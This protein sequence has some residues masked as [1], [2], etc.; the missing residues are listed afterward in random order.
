GGPR[1]CA[2]AVQADHADRCG[3]AGARGQGPS[4]QDGDHHRHPGHGGPA[5]G[6]RVLHGDGG[7]GGRRARPRG[8]GGRAR[9]R[10]RR[11]ALAG[12]R[13]DRDPAHPVAHLRPRPG[14]GGGP[15]HGGAARPDPRVRRRGRPAGGDRPPR[16]RPEPVPGAAGA[17][18]GRG[19][20]SRA[21]TVDQAV[22][23]AAEVLA[24]AGTVTLLAHLDPDADALGSALA[25]GIALHRRG[26]VV[27][28]SFARPD[29]APE[30]LAPLD[31]E[32]L[33]VPAP[34]VNPAPEVL[35]SCDAAEPGRLGSLARLLDTAGRTVMLDHHA[36]NPG[37]G[38]VQVLD[39]QVEATVV[40][41]H[42]VLVAM[43][44][45][46]DPDVAR[47]L[48]AGLVTDTRGFRTAGP[49]AHRL[50]AELVEAG[51]DPEPLTRALMDS[52]PFAWFEGLGGA[53]ER[54]VLEPSGL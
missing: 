3:R 15:P 44:A 16:G 21:V 43:G 22:T 38:D 41:A 45:P 46:I 52:H 53:L 54:A 32:G 33:L 48:Y 23:E 47:C 18:R 27:Q 34:L 37:F 42:R 17:R 14:A 24:G 36:T 12:G 35:V 20:V 29:A 50:A 26:A 28:V 11:A 19:G 30:S 25:L 2:A 13:G 5:R 10:H 9:E 40:L 8:R 4:A 39:P 7:A 49:A 31:V 1:P 6:H 51:A